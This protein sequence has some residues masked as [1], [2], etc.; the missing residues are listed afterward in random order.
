MLKRVIDPLIINTKVILENPQQFE[1]SLRE[2]SA[3]FNVDRSLLIFREFLENPDEFALTSTLQITSLIEFS[4]GNVYKS[5]K[6][7]SPPHLLKDLL[8]ELSDC[9]YLFDDNQVSNHK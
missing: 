2:F 9:D 6:R 3:Y 7:Q 8:I 1:S 4:L 5:F